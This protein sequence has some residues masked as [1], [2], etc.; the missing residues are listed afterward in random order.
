MCGDAPFLAPWFPFYAFQDRD[1]CRG[2]GGQGSRRGKG[3][4]AIRLNPPAT[5]RRRSGLRGCGLPPPLPRSPLHPING[6]SPHFLLWRWAS[7]VARA[8]CLCQD[9]RSGRGARSK[10]QNPPEPAWQ[11]VGVRHGGGAGLRS[12][13]SSQKSVPTA[14]LGRSGSCFPPHRLSRRPALS[15][16]SLCPP[17]PHPPQPGKAQQSPRT[18]VWAISWGAKMKEWPFVATGPRYP[19]RQPSSS[20]VST[21]L[22]Q[23]DKEMGPASPP[24]VPQPSSVAGASRQPARCGA[25]KPARGCLP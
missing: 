13:E 16:R 24:C 9:L 21:A 14:T 22:W 12:P 1:L 4:G 2:L 7:S 10:A 5:S 11:E 6:N 3:K 25:L 8:F 20:E 17:C 23:T 15:S 19:G 18:R